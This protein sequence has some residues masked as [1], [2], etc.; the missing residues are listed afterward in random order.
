MAVLSA[1]QKQ[2]A[3]RAAE[4]Q[5]GSSADVYRKAGTQTATGTSS[6]TERVYAGVPCD[7]SNVTSTN[8]ME[9]NVQGN[10]YDQMELFGMAFFPQEITVDDAPTAIIIRKDD[11]VE[12]D[13]IRWRATAD[14]DHPQEGSQR[15][16]VALSRPLSGVLR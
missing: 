1:S 12:C 6:A 14:M 15:V 5:M 8:P 2:A 3:R 10:G 7:I 11:V 16:R 13:G 9:Q 4:F